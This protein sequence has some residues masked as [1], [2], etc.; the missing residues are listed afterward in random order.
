MI[1]GTMKRDASGSSTTLT[2]ILRDS[3]KFAIHRFT[4]RREV[5]TMTKRTPSKS[6]GMNSRVA[7]V[8]F[9]EAA[10]ARSSGATSGATTVINA[11]VRSSSEILRSATSPPPT[12]NTFCPV[13]SKKTGK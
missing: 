10:R 1:A 13:R 4:A 7:S 3:L 8:S 2:G 11:E 12:T 5:A 6:A 9:P